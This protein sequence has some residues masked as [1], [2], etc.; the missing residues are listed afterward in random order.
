MST[1]Q[2]R[3][4]WKRFPI[5]EWLSFYI[6]RHSPR[7]QQEKWSERWQWGEL[8]K[9]LKYVVNK[10]NQIKSNQ[11]NEWKFHKPMI[12][13]IPGWT[14]VVLSNAGRPKAKRIVKMFAPIV[15]L[16]A[17]LHIPCRAALTEEKSDGN[18]APEECFLKRI[19][20]KNENWNEMN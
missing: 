20:N 9:N 14:T 12:N 1:V 6:E 3:T 2:C 7:T 11:K 10:S 13:G 19:W 4:E 16:T 17:M 15:L 5:H 18:D 8:K